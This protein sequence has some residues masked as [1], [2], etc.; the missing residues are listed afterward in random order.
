MKNK[1]LLAISALIFLLILSVGVYWLFFRPL[2]RVGDYTIYRSD[3]KKEIEFQQKVV[4]RSLSEQEVLGELVNSLKELEFV[5]RKYPEAISSFTEASIRSRCDNREID[6]AKAIFSDKDF[7]S[8][9]ILPLAANKFLGSKFRPDTSLSKVAEKAASYCINQPRCWTDEIAFAN[10]NKIPDRY[11][12]RLRRE[13]WEREGAP[14]ETPAIG[15]AARFEKFCASRDFIV[16]EEFSFSQAAQKILPGEITRQPI[17]RF[18]SYVIFQK[19]EE[20]KVAGTSKLVVF[21]FPK[22]TFSDWIGR[23]L[24]KIDHKIY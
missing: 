22:D 11:F 9:I 5:K 3:L 17:D 24:E 8:F 6:A 13:Q 2:A 15:T 21:E 16:L 7:H 19:I 20:N 12:V 4:H 1:K 10:Y 23:E 18:A 14:P